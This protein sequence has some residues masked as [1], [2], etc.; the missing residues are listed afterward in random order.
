MQY[1]FKNNLNKVFLTIEYDAVNNWY[2]TNWIGYASPENIKKGAEAYLQLL[3]ENP[4]PYLLNNNQEIVGPWDRAND[5]LEH[6]WVPQVSE[7]GL[8]YM[9]HI[10]APNIAAAL[11]G[12][13]LQRRVNGAFEMRIFGSLEK[14]I[15]WLHQNQAFET[16]QQQSLL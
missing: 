12:Q 2:Y 4:C 15:A 1:I 10:L 9:A 14:G 5:W 3:K 6:V 11:S 16:D 8:R 13:D 7:L